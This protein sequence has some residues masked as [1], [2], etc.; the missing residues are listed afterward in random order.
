MTAGQGVCVLVAAACA[1][2][3]QH[4]TQA[5]HSI[6]PGCAYAHAVL[7]ACLLWFFM[8]SMLWRSSCSVTPGPTALTPRLRASTLQAGGAR[9]SLLAFTQVGAAAAAA[10]EPHVACMHCQHSMLLARSILLARISC[11][12]STALLHLLCGCCSQQAPPSRWARLCMRACSSYWA[13]L[14]SAATLSCG[15]W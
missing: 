8:H 13:L 1:C 9:C 14:R 15:W 11:L 6:Q 4:N 3:H 2:E 7:S 12:V 10:P 5:R